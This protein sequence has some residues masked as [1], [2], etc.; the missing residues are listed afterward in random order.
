MTLILLHFL[1]CD[2]LQ[3]ALKLLN[4]DYQPNLN[5]YCVVF[6]NGIWKANET[7]DLQQELRSADYSHCQNANQILTSIWNGKEFVNVRMLSRLGYQNEIYH[8]R[9][10]ICEK[11]GIYKNKTT[12]LYMYVWRCRLTNQTHPALLVL[13]FGVLLRLRLLLESESDPDPKIW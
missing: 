13:T 1:L 8:C 4:G 9:C 10:Q 2:F 3:K 7:F 11:P 12:I 6:Q 5:V